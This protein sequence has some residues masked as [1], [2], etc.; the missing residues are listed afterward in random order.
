MMD[1]PS[2]DGVDVDSEDAYTSP[3]WTTTSPFARRYRCS[4][5][6]D[7]GSRCRKKVASDG[8]LCAVHAIAGRPGLYSTR[9]V[10]EMAGVTFRRLDYWQRQG[11]VNATVEARGSGSKRGW[12]EADIAIVRMVADL[13]DMGYTGDR[14]KVALTELQ[15]KGRLHFSGRVIAGYAEV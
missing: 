3:G 11:F 4:W 6:K 8:D 12:S 7:D 2:T 14:L 10:C 5:V 15:A 9:D 13:E 1:R